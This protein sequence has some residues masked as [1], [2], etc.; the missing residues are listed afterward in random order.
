MDI[1]LPPARELL[2]RSSA[3]G[4]EEDKM[5][6]DEPLAKNQ[7]KKNSIKRFKRQTQ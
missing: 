5:L 4:D 6:I 2:R 1:V 3:I 7:G